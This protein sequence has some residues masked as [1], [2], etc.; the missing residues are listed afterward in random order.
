[1]QMLDVRLG[2]FGMGVSDDLINAAEVIDGF[3]DVIH[4]NGF[5]GDTDGACLKDVPCLF[6]GEPA[7]LDVIGVIGEVYLHTMIDASLEFALLLFA[8]CCE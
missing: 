2:E 4:L 5:V 1:M 6:M 7:A 8:Q 3:D